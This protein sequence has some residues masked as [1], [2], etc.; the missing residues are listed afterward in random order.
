MTSNNKNQT[1]CDQVTDVGRY[2][3]DRNKDNIVNKLGKW[4]P[5]IIDAV[6]QSQGRECVDVKRSTTR[7]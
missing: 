6:A 5:V 7:G 3:N 2:Y 4:R 1:W